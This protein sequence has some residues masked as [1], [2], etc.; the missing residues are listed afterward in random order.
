MKWLIYG[1]VFAGGV[2]T[3]LWIAKMY[4][5]NKVEDAIHDGLSKVNLEGGQVENLVK[6]IVVPLTV[7]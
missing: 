4:A 1:G 6:Q 7:G 2:V 5:R 3:G